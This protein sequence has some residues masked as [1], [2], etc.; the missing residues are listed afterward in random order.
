MAMVGAYC[1]CRLTHQTNIYATATGRVGPIKLAELLAAVAHDIP[2]LETPLFIG[3]T[4]RVA[5]RLIA[6]RMPEAIV[7]ERRRVAK[8]HAKK[9]GDPPAQ[10]HLT[11]MA[12]NLF[13]PNVPPTIWPTAT[14][15]HVYPLRW[16]IE[17]S[18][19]SWKRSLHV[20]S[21]TTTKEDSTLGYLYGRML[22][23]VLH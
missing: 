3:A 12:W 11:L 15:V 18:F 16:H 8:K 5:A 9:Q 20:A 1:L 4:E 21:L 14:I 23:I 19:Q 17:L 6:M 13:M 22:L 10:A 2:L 7:N